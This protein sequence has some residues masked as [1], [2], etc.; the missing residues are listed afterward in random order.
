M[1]RQIFWLH[2]SSNPG[3]GEVGIQA[4]SPSFLIPFS[5]LSDSCVHFCQCPALPASGGTDLLTKLSTWLVVLQSQGSQT[6]LA[7]NDSRKTPGLICFFDPFR[8]VDGTSRWDQI[9]TFDFFGDPF[10]RSAWTWRFLNELVCEEIAEKISPSAISENQWK[11][12]GMQRVSVTLTLGADL[13][14]TWKVKRNSYQSR[15]TCM[16]VWQYDPRTSSDSE[17]SHVSLPWVQKHLQSPGSRQ[18]C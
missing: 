4:V 1:H 10:F 2:A 8:R 12:H 18:F 6:Y 5:I 15:P 7:H 9:P 3:E 17:A 11:S 14:T 16:T 13:F